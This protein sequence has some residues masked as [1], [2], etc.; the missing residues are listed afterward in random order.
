MAQVET[1]AGDL[2]IL[3]QGDLTPLRALPAKFQGRL[4]GYDRVSDTLFFTTDSS[5]QPI[6]FGEAEKA[7]SPPASASGLRRGA[8][9]DELLAPPA[10]ASLEGLHS[11]QPQLMPLVC[12]ASPQFRDD[13]TALCSS[14]GR[15]VFRTEDGGRSY[16][17]AMHHLPSWTGF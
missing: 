2:L 6:P 16:R 14:Y 13:Q 3:D 7:P 1:P 12:R 4:A 9:G 8:R 17:T 5:I 15:G 10:L 11:S